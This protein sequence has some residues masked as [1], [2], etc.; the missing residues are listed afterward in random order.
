MAGALLSEKEEDWVSGYCICIG[1]V[2]SGY[3]SIEVRE[4]QLI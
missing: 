4:N 2:V 3:A 1:S